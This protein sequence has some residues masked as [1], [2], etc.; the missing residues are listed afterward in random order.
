MDTKN[1][2]VGLAATMAIGTA[3]A[4]SLIALPSLTLTSEKQAQADVMSK[5]LT[6]FTSVMSMPECTIKKA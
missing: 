6:N 1:L 2:L 3:T 5:V 4:S